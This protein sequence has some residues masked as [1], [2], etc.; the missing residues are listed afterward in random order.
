MNSKILIVDDEEDIL[1]LL[2][3][4]LEKAG[5]KVISA[6]DGPEAIELAKKEKPAL[7]ILDIML[8]SME[9][10]EVCKAI[11]RDDA[12]SHIP[13]IMLTA[14]GEEVDRIV[15]L[16]LGADDY[17]TKPFSPRELVLRVKAVLK[18]GHGGEENEGTITAGNI[19][20]DLERSVVISNGK[21]LKLTATEFKLLVE[22][23]KAKGKVLSRDALLDNVRGTDYYVTDR[24][25]DTH[26]RRLREKLGKSAKHI[27]TVRGFG[28]KFMEDG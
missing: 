8:P 14:K 7:I 10:T 12:T 20:I 16:E 15:G 18:R 2:E 1:T 28:Y 9:G 27:E 25:I 24:T 4:N 6:D 13:I 3:Y 22:L 5:F 23:V 19:R 11:K 17:I 21:P 26:I